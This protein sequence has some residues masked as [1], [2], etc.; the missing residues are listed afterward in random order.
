VNGPA[1]LGGLIFNLVEPLAGHETAFRRWYA[2]DHY[3]AGAMAGPGVVAGR[4]WQGTSA[5]TPDGAADASR[6]FLGTFFLLAGTLPAYQ[7]WSATE[8]P[9]L[10]AAGRMFTQRRQVHRGRY[11]YART[12]ADAET[13]GPLSSLDRDFTA[14]L[15][16]LAVPAAPG[17]QLPGPAALAPA[18]E[19]LDI[20][21]NPVPG[22]Y[23]EVAPPEHQLVLSFRRVPADAISPGQ[24]D[25][26]V[27]RIMARGV[28]A[29]VWAGLFRPLPVHPDGV[30]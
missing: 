21:F 5:W 25:T 9:R 24:R 29:A 17:G 26:A 19:G 4:C 18:D 14:L 7:D 15:A 30:G 8:H 16:I 20:A 12:L 28:Q 1:E 23:S 22:G 6:T 2:T 13:A 27:A 3:Y 11:H 10:A